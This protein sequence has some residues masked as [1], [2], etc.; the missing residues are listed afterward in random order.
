MYLLLCQFSSDP[1]DFLWISSLDLVVLDMKIQIFKLTLTLGPDLNELSSALLQNKA[2]FSCV[3]THFMVCVYPL[4]C[5]LV[6]GNET[7]KSYILCQW[8][9][10]EASALFNKIGQ[11]WR[12]LKNSKTQG[13][14]NY[15]TLND[16]VDGGNKVF[17]KCKKQQ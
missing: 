2:N 3:L 12:L 1:L 15:P 7:C 5:R 8:S 17:A 11:Q 13:L 14:F 9:L 6:W 10:H 16:C 4:H